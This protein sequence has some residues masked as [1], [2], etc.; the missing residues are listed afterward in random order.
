MKQRISGA[1][2]ATAGVFF[3]LAPALGQSE[4]NAAEPIPFSVGEASP[5]NT[6]LA[7]WMAEEA[8]LYGAQGLTLN[9][10]PMV[11][12]RESAPALEA[13]ASSRTAG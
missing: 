12:G 9:T 3:L 5:A 8:G 6:Y 13:G 1:K 2:L 4:A 10:V 7:I 11:G